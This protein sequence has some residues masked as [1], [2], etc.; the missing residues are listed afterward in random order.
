[1]A[2]GSGRHQ[3]QLL[4]LA[5]V[6]ATVHK[7]GATLEYTSAEASEAAMECRSEEDLATT[8]AEKSAKATADVRPV[9]SQRGKKTRDQKYGDQNQA[10][11][12]GAVQSE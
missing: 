10:V 6:A 11:R 1:M 4:A 8:W 2:V 12:E 7:L 5:T 9:S 3:E